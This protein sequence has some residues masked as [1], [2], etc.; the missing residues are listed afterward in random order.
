MIVVRCPYCLELRTE[1]ELV[2]GGEAGI[3]RPP[4]PQ[5]VSDEEWTD[6]LFMRTNHKG[7]VHEQ[8]CCTHGCGQWFIVHRDSSTHAVLDTKPFE[9]AS[10]TAECEPQSRERA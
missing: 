7:T 2:H 5:L 10:S 9:S 1:E 3:V 8:W 4:Q 6:Y